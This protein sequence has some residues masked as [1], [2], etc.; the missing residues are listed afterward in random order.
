[1]G[2]TRSLFEGLVLIPDKFVPP[3]LLDRYV[4]DTHQEKAYMS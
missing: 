3:L 2:V 4:E 1:M